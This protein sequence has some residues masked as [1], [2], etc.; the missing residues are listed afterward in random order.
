MKNKNNCLVIFQDEQMIRTILS[1]LETEFYRMKDNCVSEESLTQ[2]GKI[3]E[4]IHNQ[5]KRSENPKFE[6][7]DYEQLVGKTISFIHAAQFASQITIA[8]ETK[9]VC[10]L[11]IKMNEEDENWC[12]AVNIRTIPDWAALNEIEKN[13]WL[14]NELGKVGAFDTKIYREQKQKEQEERRKEQIERSKKAR[15][16]QYLQLKE[17]FEGANNHA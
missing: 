6:I 12:E 13:E 1:A 14:R 7:V 8:T 9:E 15:Y 3:E 16:E 11:K 2:L 10:M 4:H 17:E 5:L